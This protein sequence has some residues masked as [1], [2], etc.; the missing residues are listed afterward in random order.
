V[1]VSLT[2][3]VAA[4]GPHDGHT[5]VDLFDPALHFHVLPL[6]FYDFSDGLF[7]RSAGAEYAAA[8]GAWLV[9]VG[10]T[11]VDVAWKKTLQIA[12]GDNDMSRRAAAARLLSIPE[13]LH[14]LGIAASIDRVPFTLQ[15]SDGTR[16]TIV[17]TPLETFA[18]VRWV[19]MRDRA[20]S[21]E[22]L[23]LTQARAPFG[24]LPRRF[25]FFEWFDDVKAMY[26][27]YNAVA[28]APEETVDAFFKRVFAFVDS[29]YVQKFILD[30]RHNGGGN[31]A[32]NRP[33]LLGLIK[34]DETI[35]RR[36]RLFV[37]TGRDTFSAAQNLATQLE[38]YTDAIFVGEPTG[39]SP[40]HFGDARAITLPH[41]GIHVEVSTLLWQDALPFDHRVWIAPELSTPLSSSA[42]RDGRDPAVDAVIK[43]SNDQTLPVRLRSALREG[44]K[45]A[46]AAALR[47]FMQDPLN[48]YAAVES[49]VN[50]L[51]HD[52]LAEGLAGQSLMLFEL[53][54]D[55]F[56]QSSNAIDSLG[57][58]LLA[59]GKRD[60][61]VAA[62]E[63]AVQ[64]DPQAVRS[65][66]ALERLRQ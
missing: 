14:G 65:R 48:Q 47:Q 39:G 36:G 1:I 57:E 31:N 50:R 6:S 13:V 35:N 54:T 40:N 22:P 49:Q 63:R 16:L 23:Y 66:A 37:I 58:V 38:R 11:P 34:R 15:Q 60:L 18:N 7:L 44:G 46:A 19:D 10:D 32:L 28:N 25:Y 27:Q 51:G 43:Y 5:R 21:P 26:V 12:A 9:A 45:S 59:A 42:Y 33:I 29:H 62:Y 56:P 30:L 64:L 8:T 3:A 24:L 41:S 52:L 53:N 17:A 2:G 61:A 4:I 55:T 20:G